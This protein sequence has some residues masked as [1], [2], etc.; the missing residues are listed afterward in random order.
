MALPIE[1]RVPE[2]DLLLLKELGVQIIRTKASLTLGEAI[3]LCANI[4][5]EYRARLVIL[6]GDTI[7][8]N[9]V[10][11]PNSYTMHSTA[12][13]QPWAP[14]PIGSEPQET[15]DGKMVVSG[16][17]S[18]SNIPVLLRSISLEGG[19]FLQALLAYSR[20]L[21]FSPIADGQWYDFGHIQTYYQSCGLITTQR[22]FNR[23]SILT[24]IVEK[25]SNNPSKLDAEATWFETIP[26]PLRRFTPAYLGR[27]VEPCKLGYRTANA[28]LATLSNLAVFGSLRLCVESDFDA[29][30]RF[31]IET[32]RFRDT[33]DDV[34]AA[35]YYQN[36]T[37][38]RLQRLGRF[39]TPH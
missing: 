24:D 27:M 9:T 36:K 8:E 29:C 38:A 10:L 18:F 26:E 32:S 30:D 12:D 4:I 39:A 22:S 16:F 7:I 14:A 33:S 23:V 5:G 13:Y 20:Q 17:F 15:A 37:E 2:H 21:D 35:D 31:L 1:S 11:L 28:Y 34:V 6:Y 25:F 19:D 3:S